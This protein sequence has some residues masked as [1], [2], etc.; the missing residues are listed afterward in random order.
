[1]CISYSLRGIAEVWKHMEKGLVKDLLL[2]NQE[3]IVSVVF[4]ISS[5]VRFKILA[6]LF[7]RPFSFND[8]IKRTFVQKTTL[9]NH[10]RILMSRN[11]I[12]KIKHGMYGITR[13]GTIYLGYT[14]DVYNNTRGAGKDIKEAEKRK[15]IS[16]MF[17]E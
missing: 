8:L 4:A 3:E 13:K 12:R 7:E 6:L 1:M 2:E 14:F 16:G 9:S 15:R 11:L 5:P 10:L 17:F